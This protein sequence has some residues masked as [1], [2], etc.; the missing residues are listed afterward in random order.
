MT[1]CPSMIPSDDGPPYDMPYM[2]S[3]FL[4]DLEALRVN[5]TAL[6]LR[7]HRVSR[8]VE[9]DPTEQEVCETCGSLYV[10]RQHC[11]CGYIE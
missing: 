5:S 2:V 11:D 1:E 7:L 10:A 4:R 3:E 6:R 9:P 8:K